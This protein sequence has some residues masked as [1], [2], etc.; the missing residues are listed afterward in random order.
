MK[1]LYEKSLQKIRTLSRK[2]NE[3]EWNVIATLENYLSSE[4][5]KYISGMAFEELCKSVDNY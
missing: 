3:R 1:E 4:S 2:P 5:L